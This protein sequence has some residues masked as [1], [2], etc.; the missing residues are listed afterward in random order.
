MC[1]LGVGWVK[2]RVVGAVS[3]IERAGTDFLA[4]VVWKGRDE[5]RSKVM[6]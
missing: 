5:G 6:T 3:T 1:Q 2:V 4:V